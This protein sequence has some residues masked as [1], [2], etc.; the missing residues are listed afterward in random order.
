MRKAQTGGR[1]EEAQLMAALL[2]RYPTSEYA[3]LQQ[4]R[5]STGF[6]RKV[7]RTAD[8]LA[9]SLWPSR[10]LVL[11]GFEI[12]S[13]RG[14][15][16]REL[17]QPAKAEEIARFCDFWWLVVAHHGIVEHG[18]LPPTWGLLSP[19][20]KGERLVVEVPAPRNEKPEPWSRGFM[21]AVLRNASDC[22]VPAAAV[23]AQCEEHYRKGHDVGAAKAPESEAERELKRLRELEQ[24]VQAFER[25]SGINITHD[26]RGMD[27]VGQAVQAVLRGQDAYQRHVDRLVGLARQMPATLESRYAELKHATDSFV[28][29]LNESAASFTA[30]AD[31]EV[32]A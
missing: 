22:S 20:A 31:G 30:P 21:A 14:D 25:A 28:A 23:A 8:A 29:V 26:Y 11:H 7:T 6:A 13:Y 24:K 10:G 5:N 15:W 19:D 2:K 9:F 12:K 1:M 32:E 3:F 4:V 18:E 16:V 27:K 17:R